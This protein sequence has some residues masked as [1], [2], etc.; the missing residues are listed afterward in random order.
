VRAHLLVPVHDDSG[1]ILRGNAAIIA[2]VAFGVLALFSGPEG[3]MAFGGMLLA[4]ALLTGVMM[5][6]RAFRQTGR[7]R[8]LE[9]GAAQWQYGSATNAVTPDTS[10]VKAD[11]YP[12]PTGRHRHRYWDGLSWTSHVSDGGDT[13]LDPIPRA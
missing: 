13:S 4:S 12:D 1:V 8:H 11:W 10:V 6:V 3:Q 2:L 9:G 7:S 5:A